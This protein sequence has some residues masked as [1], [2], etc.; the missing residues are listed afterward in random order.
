MASMVE[1]E[2]IKNRKKNTQK[3]V[4]QGDIHCPKQKHLTSTAGRTNYVFGGEG[5]C[6]SICECDILFGHVFLEP[7][8]ALTKIYPGTSE[9]KSKKHTL[10][11]SS[12]A[13]VVMG[14]FKA[15]LVEGKKVHYHFPFKKGQPELGKTHHPKVEQPSSLLTKKPIR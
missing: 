13:H 9:P 5:P 6:M 11:K 7:K 3:E 14:K 15:C 12:L 1:T 10:Q 8:K 4:Q 2:K